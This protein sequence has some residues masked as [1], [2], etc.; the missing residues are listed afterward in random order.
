MKVLVTGDRNWI[1]REAIRFCL[2][3]LQQQGYDSLV[4]GGARGADTIA[5][6][7]A[8]KLH[9]RSIEHFPAQWNRY[10]RAAG[11]IRNRTMLDQSKP[12]LVVYFHHNLAESKGTRDMVNYAISCR[13]K[14][15]NGM[16]VDHD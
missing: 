12:N 4:E 13:I 14:V 7:E 11:P 15:I 8:L 16:E 5:H 3:K 1:D 6:E 2:S 10:G 9:Y